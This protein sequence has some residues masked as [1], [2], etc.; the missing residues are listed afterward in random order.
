M[1]SVSVD[2]AVQ[3]NNLL[4]PLFPVTLGT[5]FFMIA[6]NSLFNQSALIYLLHSRERVAQGERNK[7]KYNIVSIKFSRIVDCDL[8]DAITIA[9]KM[10]AEFAPSYGT[11]VNDEC[12]NELWTSEK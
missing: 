3:A 10:N 1:I 7:M 11:Q 4:Y 8:D 6:R 2:S 5:V 9:Q 12:G